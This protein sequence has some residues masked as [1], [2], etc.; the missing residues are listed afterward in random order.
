VLRLKRKWVMALC[1]LMVVATQNLGAQEWPVKPIRIMVNV[2]PGGG[3]DQ[4]TRV[5]APRLSEALGQ[6]VVVDNRGGAGG[7]IGVEQVAK[8]APD[9]YTLLA[10]IGSTIVMGPHLY[11]LSFDA[12]R[13]LLPIAPIARTLMFLVARNSLP[14]NN[15]AELVAYARANPGK[16]NFGSPGVGT[17]PHIATEMMLR[18]AKMQATHIPYKG[19]AETMAALFGNTIDFAFDPGSA[20][21]QAR[22]GKL[23]LL[24]VASAKRS[25]LAPDAP[26]L[27]EA[28]VEVDSST[29]HGLYAPS[30][31]PAAIAV[32]LHREFD[33][34][35]R[36]PEAVK[37]VA[38]VTAESV[39]ATQEE[40]AAQLRRDRERYG[41]VIR[42]AGIRAE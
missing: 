1:A 25:P 31:T 4:I 41:L 38:A 34:V 37:A 11:K 20:V 2:P 36:G 16:L 13:D 29:V 7:N 35:M 14:V 9:G 8:A 33:R 24:A 28:G 18:A 26:T 5:A 17:G 39:Y 10:A 15:V 32:R 6:P 3:I 42:E 12:G 27:A 22:A 21:R 30:G 40:F 19:S 23:R